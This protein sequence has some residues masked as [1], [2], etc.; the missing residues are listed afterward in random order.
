[1]F[2]M[3]SKGEDLFI[4]LVCPSSIKA[5]QAGRRKKKQYPIHNARYAPLM[6]N[7]YKNKNINSFFL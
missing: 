7:A 6:I 3:K 5:T 4:L 2:V 1:M